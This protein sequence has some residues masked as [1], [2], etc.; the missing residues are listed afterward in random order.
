MACSEKAYGSSLTF[1]VKISHF[2]LTDPIF[3]NERCLTSC[4][5][6]SL[7]TSGPERHVSHLNV[8]K[9]AARSK[10]LSDWVVS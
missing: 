6:L 5:F 3:F 8:I 2:D 10:V 9:N 7:K 1:R 4:N